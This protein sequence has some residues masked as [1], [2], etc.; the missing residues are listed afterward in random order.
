MTTLKE[1]QS[2]ISKQEE[3]SSTYKNL[4]KELIK[5]DASLYDI[6]SAQNKSF[7]ASKLSYALRQALIEVSKLQE[8]SNKYL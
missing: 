6:M 4:T 3:L 2:Q 1:L 8:E 7:I 5:S